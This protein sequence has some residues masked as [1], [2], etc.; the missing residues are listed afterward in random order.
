MDDSKSHLKDRLLLSPV[1]QW[2]SL[3]RNLLLNIGIF[4]LII[5]TWGVVKAVRSPNTSAA[6]RKSLNGETAQTLLAAGKIEAAQAC[7]GKSFQELS[8]VAPD[9]AAF[10]EITFLI[11][12]QRYQEALERSVSLKERLSPE[13]CLYSQN[14]IRIANLHRMLNNTAGEL[15]AWHDFEQTNIIETARL[16]FS[17]PNLTA[18]PVL[19]ASYI[20][21]R[22]AAI[23]LKGLR[24][25]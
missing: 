17:I 19:F 5:L 6:A 1:G 16:G 10:S 21:E 23:D 22:E 20:Q 4:L 14:L 7:I 8:I 3:H 13:T 11:A 12:Q 9:Y 24:D 2:M 25:F 18:A 15:A